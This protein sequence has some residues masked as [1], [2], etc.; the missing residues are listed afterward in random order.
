MWWGR[1]RVGSGKRVIEH[2]LPGVEC[3]KRR[4]AVR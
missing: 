4:V 3:F 1:G 2:M